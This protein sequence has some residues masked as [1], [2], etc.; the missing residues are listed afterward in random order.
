MPY[1]APV[2][3][4]PSATGT[5]LPLDQ[6]TLAAVIASADGAFGAMHVNAEGILQCASGIDRDRA[7]PAGAAAAAVAGVVRGLGA[8]VA[9]GRLPVLER[10]CCEFDGLTLLVQA[11]ADGSVIALIGTEAADLGAMGYA[12]SDLA[13]R[14]RSD[15][16]SL[17]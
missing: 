4:G 10:V 2:S 13:T 12:L 6:G 3:D 14:L 7:E 16:P 8:A 1:T 9:A 15:H 5:L 11:L 17:H